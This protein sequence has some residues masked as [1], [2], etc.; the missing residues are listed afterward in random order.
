MMHMET[1]TLRFQK[2]PPEVHPFLTKF[3]NQRRK[4]VA[5]PA[6]AGKATQVPA[7]Y[8]LHLTVKCGSCTVCLGLSEG[9][10][11]I[12]LQVI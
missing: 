1:S 9:R 4:P 7:T 5:P 10:L 3:T 12:H 8:P 6:D 2:R 11:L